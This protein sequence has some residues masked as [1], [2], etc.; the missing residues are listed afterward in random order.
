[1]TPA[2]LYLMASI[3][4]AKQDGQKS[5]TVSVLDLAEALRDI[6]PSPETTDRPPK[7]VGYAKAEKLREMTHGYRN[8]LTLR[9]TKDRDFCAPLFTE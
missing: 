1:M 6:H 3:E 9:R 5:I 8:W 2:A 4:R 7:L